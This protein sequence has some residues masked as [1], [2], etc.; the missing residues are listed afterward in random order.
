MKENTCIFEENKVCLWDSGMGIIISD[1]RM[2][3]QQLDLSA[4]IK[5]VLEFSGKLP[6]KFKNE[7]SNPFL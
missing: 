3:W 1:G 6:F 4:G 7:E 5:A 2:L